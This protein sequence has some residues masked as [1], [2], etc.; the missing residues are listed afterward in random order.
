MRY[1]RDIETEPVVVKVRFECP[2]CGQ[3]YVVDPSRLP[4][5]QKC[6]THN[7][8]WLLNLSA[9]NSTVANLKTSRRKAAET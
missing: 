4:F 9:Q 2:N 5:S 3:G 6:R 8:D 7:C 1:E